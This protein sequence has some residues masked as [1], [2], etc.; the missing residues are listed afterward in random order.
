MPLWAP[1]Q[2]PKGVYYYVKLVSSRAGRRKNTRDQAPAPTRVTMICT[3]AR[4]IRTDYYVVSPHNL[5]E[6]SGLA[7]KGA[8]KAPWVIRWL[9]S[10]LFL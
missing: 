5:R 4:H 10:Q 7:L 2:G 1:K 9:E 6:P 8:L 3:R